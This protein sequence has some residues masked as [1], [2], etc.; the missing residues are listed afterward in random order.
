MSTTR[1]QA[2]TQARPHA[3]SLGART[4][5]AAS[6][7]AVLSTQAAWAGPRV[8]SNVG[9]PSSAT[10]TVNARVVSSTP[11]VA[12]VATPRQACYDEVQATQAQSSGAG[13]ILGAIAGA[14]V[15]N[16]IGRG[17]G[18]AI[19]TGVGLMGGAVLGNHIETD[20]KPG[21]Q[22]TVRRCENQTAY[23][24]QVVAYSVEYELNGQ[25]YSTQLPQEP[26]P[27]IPIQMT[28]SPAVSYQNAPAYPQ[29]APVYQQPQAPVYQPQSAPIYQQQAPVYQQAPVVQYEYRYAQPGVVTVYDDRP[30][31]PH[32][33]GHH[34]D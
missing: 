8:G 34:W 31:R 12:Q 2:R 27:T 28:V 6:T 20:G 17:S 7:L 14:A 18:R 21:G 9:T 29:T 4:L 1:L 23:E 19:A 24:N 32:H 30:Y 10:T 3:L 11:V 33:R 25:R 13:A 5:L 15:G 16:A 26:G 22:R